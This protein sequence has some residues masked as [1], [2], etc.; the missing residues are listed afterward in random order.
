MRNRLGAILEE[1]YGDCYRKDRAKLQAARANE[2]LQAPQ[3]VGPKKAI[4]P[5][6]K[7]SATTLPE[8]TTKDAKKRPQR[9]K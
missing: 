5:A 9:S 2:E 1:R 7:P 6:S 8:P 3:V 4:R